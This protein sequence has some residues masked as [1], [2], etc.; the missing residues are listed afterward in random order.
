MHRLISRQV[1]GLGE[2]PSDVHILYDMEDG[3]TSFLV[4]NN[5]LQ[6][7]FSSVKSA[8]ARLY[9]TQVEIEGRWFEPQWRHCTLSSA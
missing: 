6:C 7:L 8:V 2:K 5:D 3:V 9:S 1:V 4:S